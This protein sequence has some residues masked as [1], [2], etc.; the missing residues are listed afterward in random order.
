MSLATGDDSSSTAFIA[1][2][3]WPRERLEEWVG[4]YRAVVE[5]ACGPATTREDR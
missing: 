5:R 4:E 1:P 2:R 3:S